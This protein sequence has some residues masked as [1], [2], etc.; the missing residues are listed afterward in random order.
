MVLV[1]VFKF[2]SRFAAQVSREPLGR[3]TIVFVTF[4]MTRIVLLLLIS[5]HFAYSGTIR[6]R[7]TDSRTGEALQ[8]TNVVLLGTNLGAMADSSGKYTILNVPGGRWFLQTSQLG[9][10]KRVDTLTFA[11]PDSEI[12]LHINLS[13]DCAP[14]GDLVAKLLPSFERASIAAY[15]D[16]LR[17]LASGAPLLMLSIDSLSCNSDTTGPGRLIAYLSFRNSTIL[18]LHVLKDYPCLRRLTAFIQGSSGDTIST[19]QFFIDFV[20]EKCRYE[21]SDLLTV[22]PGAS[23]QYPPT[24][25]W[26]YSCSELPKGVYSVT[27]TYSYSMP[28]ILDDLQGFGKSQLL[29]Y[30]LAIQGSFQSVNRWTLTIDHEF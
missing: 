3:A 11:S 30:L 16:S 15:H 9:Y 24:T 2:S 26:P 14:I 28:E 29:P 27:I 12:E 7:V 22:P 19:H 10:L 13:C 1:E 18:P 25:V 23:I 17:H 20:G 4:D 6:G 8:G 5:S 21:D